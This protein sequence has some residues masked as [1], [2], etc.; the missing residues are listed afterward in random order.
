MMKII[1]KCVIDIETLEV[2]SEESFNYSGPVDQCKG[3]GSSGTVDYPDYMKTQHEAWLTDL[4]GKMT[5][6]SPFATLTAYDPSATLALSDAAIDAFL[7]ILAGIAS[8]TTIWASFFT[9]GVTSVGAAAT[10]TAVSDVV[11]ADK[12]SP[13]DISVIAATELLTATALADAAALEVILDSGI[14]ARTLPRFRRGMQDIDAVVSSAF[15]IG[16]AIIEAFKQDEV[17]KHYTGL[18]ASI[19]AKNADI[20]IANEQI[21][22]DVEKANLSKEVS[23]A[24]ANLGKSVDVAKLNMGKSLAIAEG[25]LR[26]TIEYKKMYLEA[27]SQMMR[28]MVQRVAFHETWARMTIESNR[29]AIV[30]SKEEADENADLDEKN[31]R[32]GFEVFQYGANMLGAVS[33]GSVGTQKASRA[34]SAIGGALSGAASGAMIGSVVPGIGTAVG[35]LVGG[36][37]G[38]IGGLAS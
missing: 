31:A 4:D 28:E 34:A 23:I 18:S 13:T 27:S 10:M 12:A 6:A 37:I 9:Q 5:T 22:A 25:N 14:A 11:V 36:A 3:G 20:R 38:L 15:P 30:A 21:A 17:T 16:E 24:E 8:D 1:T 7:A 26:S 35:A 29:I 33:G 19:Y 32:W 2:I